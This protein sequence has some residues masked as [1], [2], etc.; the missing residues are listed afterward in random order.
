MH[1]V[2]ILWIKNM[3][4]RKV[5]KRQIKSDGNVYVEKNDKNHLNGE[6]E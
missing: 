2:N 6:E 5:W 4:I 3:D 1:C